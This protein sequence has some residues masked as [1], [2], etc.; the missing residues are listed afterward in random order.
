MK[1]INVEYEN[2]INTQ[3]NSQ[4]EVK[5]IATIKEAAKEFIPAQTQNIATLDSVPTNADISEKV[6]KEG[7]T[8]EFRINVISVNGEDYRI[9]NSVLASLKEILVI[10]PELKT[11][12][13]TKTGSDL[14][15]KYTVI[16]LD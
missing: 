9:P 8:D 6:F 5:K 13:V 15:T 11:F 2:Y 3:L 12:K 16:P 10:K 4:Q 1:V 7:T 14:S